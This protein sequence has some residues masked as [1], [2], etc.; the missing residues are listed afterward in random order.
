MT[1]VLPVLIPRSKNILLLKDE[2]GKP[3]PTT[4]TLPNSSFRY[5]KPL[6]RD[7]LKE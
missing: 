3:K 6:N 7:S 4:R 1:T 2:V 5:G